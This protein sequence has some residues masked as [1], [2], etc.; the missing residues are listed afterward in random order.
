M[1]TLTTTQTT[2]L[3]DMIVDAAGGTGRRGRVMVTRD[4]GVLRRSVTF[5]DDRRDLAV[6]VTARARRGDAW[7]VTAELHPGDCVDG[8]WLPL[9][10]PDV[11]PLA[12]ILTR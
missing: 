12:R 8:D 6:M 4:A 3:L 1:T 5:D 11:A 7:D 10:L 2:A 9:P